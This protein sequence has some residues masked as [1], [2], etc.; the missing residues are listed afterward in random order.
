VTKVD[1]CHRTNSNQNPYV[2][3][4]PDASGDVS[5][6]DG[7]DGPVWDDSLKE[8]HIKWGDI[9]P[10]FKYSGGDQDP[11]H[12]IL[13]LLQKPPPQRLPRSFA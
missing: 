10:P 11:D 6:H 12:Q 1:I 2:V 7:H 9:I 5:G 13:E 4:A 8:N 3:N